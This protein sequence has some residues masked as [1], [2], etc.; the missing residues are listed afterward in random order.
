MLRAKAGG[1]S[2][3]FFPTLIRKSPHGEERKGEEREGEG[4]KKKRE[5]EGRGRVAE[6]D[7]APGRWH[8][9]IYVLAQD[10]KQNG[11]GRKR[12][13]CRIVMRALRQ[14]GEPQCAKTGGRRRIDFRYGTC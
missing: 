11:R 7:H 2:S 5:R 3:R 1:S 8:G 10:H 9:A 4:L 13:Q 12:V 14:R 6:G